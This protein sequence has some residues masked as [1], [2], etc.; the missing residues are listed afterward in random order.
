MKLLFNSDKFAPL[1]KSNHTKHRKK[2]MGI[3]ESIQAQMNLI[4]QKQDMLMAAIKALAGGDVAFDN[5]NGEQVA[6]VTPDAP[7][8]TDE[9][10]A[11]PQQENIGKGGID[12]NSLDETGVPW[13]ERIHSSNQKQSNKNVWAKRRGVQPAEFNKV[14]AELVAK[15]KISSAKETV[16]A[17]PSPSAPAAPSAP[18]APAAKQAPAAPT[19]ELSPQEQSKKDL[20]AAMNKLTSD[21]DVS[22]D[23][24]LTLL[25]KFNAKTLDTLDPA[26]YDA[27]CRDFTQW[28]DWLKMIDEEVEKIREMAGDQA[29]EGIQIC[30]DNVGA[31]SLSE[32]K[33]EDCNDCHNYMTDFRK[34][35][36]DYIASQA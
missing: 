11:A 34:S 5:V 13:D 27:A 24:C 28:A 10:P 30:F 25:D 6:N 35:W 12:L 17:P 15:H 36:D 3:I 4:S 9:A 26:N 18:P 32:V 22:F 1:I 29:E 16:S 19:A 7:Q 14:H 31:K 23:T 20:I 21:Y 8:Q 33:F 2:I